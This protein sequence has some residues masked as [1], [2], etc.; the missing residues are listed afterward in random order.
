MQLLK[1]E[2]TAHGCVGVAHTKSCDFMQNIT[3][4]FKY[5]LK[6]EF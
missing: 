5:D 6:E 4:M 1:I 3:L 2:T